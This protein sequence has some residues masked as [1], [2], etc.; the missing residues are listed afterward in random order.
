MGT[1][2]RVTLRGTSDHFPEPHDMGIYVNSGVSG[3]L[4]TIYG[5]YYIYP[6]SDHSPPYPAPIPPFPRQVSASAVS[7][8]NTASTLQNVTDRFKV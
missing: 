8:S 4:I 7:L 5:S 6:H 3:P 1:T 2:A